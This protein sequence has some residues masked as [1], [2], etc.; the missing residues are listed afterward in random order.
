MLASW[1]RSLQSEP[2]MSTLGLR[3]SIPCS[4]ICLGLLFFLGSPLLV[5]WFTSLLYLACMIFGIYGSADLSNEVQ[6]ACSERRESV[7]YRLEVTGT[8]SPLGS[9]AKEGVSCAWPDECGAVAFLMRVSSKASTLRGGFVAH[10]YWLALPTDH[11]GIS[12]YLSDGS[13]TPFGLFDRKIWFCLS[14]LEDLTMGPD[15]SI[16]PQGMHPCF[17]RVCGSSLSLNGSGLRAEFWEVKPI[18]SVVSLRGGT[19]VAE[20]CSEGGSRGDTSHAE[21]FCTREWASL[22]Y[23]SPGDD[24]VVMALIPS[25]EEALLA[26]RERLWGCSGAESSIKG[27]MSPISLPSLGAPYGV[28]HSI[29]VVATDHVRFWLENQLMWLLDGHVL[30][31]SRSLR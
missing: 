24:W 30:F 31:G 15:L 17:S 16:K 28:L 8:L 9:L 20:A 21:P 29:S 7:K 1:E 22:H 23:A 14:F 6:G 25:F 11:R 4:Q 19:Q 27:D 13:M 2:K 12:Q 18:L 10:R 3:P 26:I 5:L